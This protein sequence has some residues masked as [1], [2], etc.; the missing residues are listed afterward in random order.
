MHFSF[1][2]IQLQMTAVYLSSMLA[3][4]GQL[5]W[6][7]GTAFYYFSQ[8]TVFGATGPTGP[9]VRALMR[10]EWGSP[11]VTWAT[12]LIETALIA[13]PWVPSSALRFR[14][15]VLVLMFHGTIAIALGLPTFGLVVAG[16]SVLA[17]Q[18]F[19]REV[20]HDYR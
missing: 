20:P 17:L 11:V 9:V 15:F 16:M 2:A 18:P 4:L 13:A 10:S 8:D 14:L 19:E 5:A 7:E 1:F 12:L 6:T 3:K